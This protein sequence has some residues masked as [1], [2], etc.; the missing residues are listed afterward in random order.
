MKIVG[1]KPNNRKHAFEVRT[2]QKMLLFPY[3]ECDPMPSS[4]DR[5]VDAYVDQE[6]GKEAFTYRLE[7]GA[8]GT[9]HIDS[10]L[11]YNEDPNYLADLA[12]YRLTTEA[13]K[14]FDSSPLS[15]REIARLLGTSPTQLYR[16]LDPTN[17][18]KSLRQMFS[19]LHVL[20][21]QLELD[22]KDLPRRTVAG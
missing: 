21:L 17:Y 1:V 14:K 22:V 18:S 15:A 2:R 19:L 12:F 6:L 9:I 11:E 3:S 10:V 4:G 13:R 16:L 5:V 8:E 7:S 20:G